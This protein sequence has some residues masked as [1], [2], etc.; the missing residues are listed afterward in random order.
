MCSM[1]ST[2]TCLL[3]T[4]N[5]NESGD[6]S[7]TCNILGLDIINRKLNILKLVEELGPYLI[8][9]DVNLRCRGTSAFTK[10]LQNLPE[11]FLSE[12]E[13]S[14]IAVFFSDRLKDHHSV[15]PAVL[16]GILI[17]VKMKNLPSD[18]SVLLATSLFRNVV[19]YTQVQSD[20]LIYY[21]ILHTLITERSKDLQI[22]SSEFVHGVISAMDGE[23]DPRNLMFLF[24]ML[25]EF[26]TFFPLGQL[27]EDT[28]EVIG[29]YFPVDFNPA[30]NDTQAITRE[31]LAN[32]L[33][34]CLTATPEFGEF[35]I[36]LISEKLDSDLRQ[37]KIDS[38]VLLR[39]GC[40]V[41]KKETLN[42]YC[43]E[44]WPLIRKELLPPADAQLQELSCSALKALL[45]KLPNT[46]TVNLVNDII[47]GCEGLLT[48]TQL[49]LFEPASKLLLTAAQA[50]ELSC[51]S[52]VSKVFP[53]L[54]SLQ[55]VNSN[56]DS[57]IV[58][59]ALILFL[60]V[61][62]EKNLDLFSEGS[63]LSDVWSDIV[64]VF[65][66]GIHNNNIEVRKSSFHAFAVLA[67]KI[68]TVVTS[69]LCSILLTSVV[70]EKAVNVRKEVMECLRALARKNTREVESIIMPQLIIDKDEEMNLQV[71][72]WRYETLCSLAV[73]NHF[74]SVVA[75]QFVYLVS[76][77]TQLTCI[78]LKCLR[79]SLYKAEHH[80][81]AFIDYLTHKCNIVEFLISWWLQRVAN[82]DP[83]VSSEENLEDTSRII[84]TLIRTLSSDIQISVVEPALDILLS[85]YNGGGNEQNLL[86]VNASSQYT[87]VVS[88]LEALLGSLKP[89]VNILNKRKFDEILLPLALYSNHTLTQTSAVRLLASIINKLQPDEVIVAMLNRIEECIKHEFS[90]ENL[91]SQKNAALLHIFVTKALVLRGH[92]IMYHWL[93]KL[94]ELIEHSIVGEIAA[95]GFYIIMKESDWYLNYASNSNIRLLY[96]QRLFMV[97]PKIVTNYKLSET[98]NK[99]NYLTTIAHIVQGVPHTVLVAQLPQ[100]LPMLVQSIS[101]ESSEELTLVMLSTLQSLLT[102]KERVL[103][104]YSDT[105]IPR[106]LGISHTSTFMKVR[107]A[108]LKCL[109]RYLDYSPI[110]LLPYKQ[111]VIRELEACLDDKKR[112]V[113]QEAARTRSCWFLLGAPT[114]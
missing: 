55:K 8:S 83:L 58:I 89:D 102:A 105:F 87:Q 110:L 61:C 40:S 91:N 22:I 100:I 98:P 101:A 66:C 45:A 82:D 65:I 26:L 48:D 79:E 21:Q 70:S 25:P 95:N 53:F 84:D 34:G 76:T 74:M 73:N 92:T 43:R 109:R 51:I 2:E 54:L 29:C 10:V 112:L 77:C 32:A 49:S 6:I 9:T 113:R 47:F 114:P 69:Q 41:W 107:I 108:A 88:L 20:R 38:L 56:S 36:P 75:E 17:M 39:E 104:E 12:K 37:A 93:D 30:G 28:F 44:L 33:L 27:T 52:I 60:E 85:T 80:A 13:L 111:R 42:K 68:D 46:G 35:C 86:N 63:A 57:V 31:D 18:A 62:L 96:R 90:T 81:K 106:F 15:I 3:L 16:H 24:R 94:I 103:E 97:V 78:A 14:F 59:D 50:S 5:F 19:C 67:S 1:A 71:Q 72:R 11:N 7:E 64:Q 23:R 4:K 99:I